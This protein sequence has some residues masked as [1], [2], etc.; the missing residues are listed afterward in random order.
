M[1]GVLSS[2]LKELMSYQG[3]KQKGLAEVMGVTVDRVKNL[4]RGRAGNL[5]REE[6]EALIRKL[7]VR[8]EWLATGDGPMFRSSSEEEL[9]RRL[10]AVAG[11]TQRAQ[12][13]GLDADAQTRVQMLLTGIEIG[14]S[15]L[16]LQALNVLSADEKALLDDYRQSATEGKKALRSTA[17]VFANSAVAT[18]TD[19]SSKH[20]HIDNSK[21]SSSMTIQGDNNHVVGGRIIKNK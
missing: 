11:A 19:T 4:T 8:A 5:T 6:G 9:E 20:T 14:N 7:N 12:M 2:Q 13:S 17:R 16:V 10:D 18:Q 1:S 21:G 3:L 15:D